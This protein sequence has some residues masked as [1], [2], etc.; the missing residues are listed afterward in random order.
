MPWLQLPT[1]ISLCEIWTR[2][3]QFFFYTVAQVVVVHNSLIL[4]NGDV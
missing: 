1:T 3:A 2:S 4:S